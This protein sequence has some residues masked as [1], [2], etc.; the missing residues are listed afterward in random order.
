MEKRNK[1]SLAYFLLLSILILNITQNIDST[2]QNLCSISLDLLSVPL[3]NSDPFTLGS[4]A[5]VEAFCTDVGQDGSSDHPY[6]IENIEIDGTVENYGIS[7]TGISHHVLLRNI[8]IRD[9]AEG[10]ALIISNCDNI[11]LS[12]MSITNCKNAISISQSN[13]ITVEKVSIYGLSGN[14]M[15]GGGGGISIIQSTNI[16]IKNNIVN[17]SS[18]SVVWNNCEFVNVSQNQCFTLFRGFSASN[19]NFS[20]VDHNILNTDPIVMISGISLTLG[21]DNIYYNNSIRLFDIGMSLSTSNNC[22]LIEN[23]IMDN[24]N[25]GIQLVDA[26]N[27]TLRDNIA[28]KN[29]QNFEMDVNSQD[30]ILINNI[31]TSILPDAPVWITTDHTINVRRFSLEWGIVPAVNSYDLFVNSSYFDSTSETQYEFNFSENVEYQFTLIAS[32]L[33]GSSSASDM[34][35]ITAVFISFDGGMYQD[36]IRLEGNSA[37]ETLLRETDQDG[38]KENPYIIQDIIIQDQMNNDGLILSDIT[39]H[40]LIQNVTISNFYKE[41]PESEGGTGMIISNCENIQIF[42]NSIEY[43]HYGL[44]ISSSNNLTISNSS[45]SNLYWG[46]FPGGNAL[47]L[48]Q[49]EN[50]SIS[51]NK[52]EDNVPRAIYSISCQ[53]IAVFDNFC[54]GTWIGIEF[55]NSNN[56]LIKSNSITR[57]DIGVLIQNGFNNLLHKNHI[58]LMGTGVCLDQ[59]RDSL[60]LQNDIYNNTNYGME[61]LD[62]DSNTF[63]ENLLFNNLVN[64][65]IDANSENNIFLNNIFT[66]YL[67]ASPEWITID[68]TITSPIITLEWESV[69]KVDE[70]L[71]YINDEYLTTIQQTIFEYSFQSMGFCSFVILAQ[72]RSGLSDPSSILSIEYAVPSEYQLPPTIQC[73][74]TS[75]I[76]DYMAPPYPL[77]FIVT[78]PYVQS[79]HFELFIDS[80]CR[81]NSSWISGQMLSYFVEES[82]L[83][84]YNLTII[85]YDGYGSSSSHYISIT[86]INQAPDIKIL[87]NSLEFLQDD[88]SSQYIEWYFS[89][90]SIENPT[91]T[92]VFNGATDFHDVSCNPYDIY[93]FTFSDLAIGT[94]EMTL[95]VSDGLGKVSTKVI[96]VK[97]ISEITNPTDTTTDSAPDSTND[98]PTN[99]STDTPSKGDSLE[100]SIPGYES[101][102]FL[103]L[104]FLGLVFICVSVKKSNKIRN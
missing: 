92:L 24:V 53:Q 41:T 100:F 31:F 49:S 35:S 18:S 50:I 12:N 78:D 39:H 30:N 3:S 23:V 76:V 83:A 75:L 44:Q 98:S 68:Q 67:P 52:F 19:S 99:S 8:T 91:Y 59:T 85:A 61:L 95:I 94:Y 42:N 21:H 13:F 71:L 80:E 48:L 29:G 33:S 22:S 93:R 4:N 82:V 77:E 34:H 45:I 15:M 54:N 32:N 57:G 17:A 88:T 79:P 96:S 20:L 25:Y 65:Q 97:I 28:I 72:N 70:Y 43:C 38:T 46:T 26:D 7:L 84:T 86:I 102:I 87:T 1:K 5:A 60:F 69:P 9:A 89:D 36:P 40:V 64:F 81:V 101:L 10:N 11:V 63:Q 73:N 66:A 14:P 51:N 37:I 58:W 6:V 104:T 27:N 90:P 16:T 55:L 103:P 47:T 62:A 2:D 74:F 56:S